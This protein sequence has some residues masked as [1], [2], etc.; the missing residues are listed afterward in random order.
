MMVAA[1]KRKRVGGTETK[2]YQSLTSLCVTGERILTN[3]QQYLALSFSTVFT[4]LTAKTSCIIRF[5]TNHHDTHPLF[6]SL[7]LS[8]PLSF[9]I[10]QQCDDT[11]GRSR[12]REQKKI[13]ICAHVTVGLVRVELKISTFYSLQ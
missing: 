12:A 2:F 11:S 8:P 9:P 6:F 7:F 4:C 10:Y 5:V 1:M 3:C 13:N